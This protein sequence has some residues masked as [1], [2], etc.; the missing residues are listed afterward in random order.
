MS[1][2]RKVAILL[3]L[4]FLTP[5]LIS[6]L[7]PNEMLLPVSASSCNST[8]NEP[9][10]GV[11]AA[12][13]S[14]EN[15]YY[16]NDY[17][18][19]VEE[20]GSGGKIAVDEPMIYQ[21]QSALGTLTQDDDFSTSQVM[22]NDS[23]SGLR[24]NLTTGQKYTFCITTQNLNNGSI[25]GSSEVDV[26]LLTEYDWNIYQDDYN[27]RNAEWRNWKNDV[28]IEWQSYMSSFYW[29]PFRDVHEYTKNSNFEFSVA[30]DQPLVTNTMFQD[31]G[32]SWEEFYLIVD[33][34]DNVYDDAEPTGH[35]VQVDIQVMI[36]ERF[37]LPNWTVS[38]TCCGLFLGI[39]AIP[40]VLHVRYQKAGINSGNSQ[41]IPKVSGTDSK[42]FGTMKDDL[43]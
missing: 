3:S 32:P 34:W 29:K 28:P 1:F 22:Q 13:I 15:Y 21:D 30:L 39:A 38:V 2:T 19:E 37:A 33:G 9:L 4:I 40:A 16:Y 35:E 17:F 42:S 12:N 7:L 6:N 18:Y 24:L 14:I 10:W 5:L 20:G 8:N 25:I 23:I 36:E 26:Y 27:A 11:E 43:E 31:S 41:L